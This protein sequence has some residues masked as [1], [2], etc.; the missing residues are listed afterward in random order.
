VPVKINKDK[1]LTR[2]TSQ[3]SR[4]FLY[5]SLGA[6]VARMFRL[7]RARFYENGI[8]SCNL[9]WDGQTLQAKATRSTHSHVLHLLSQLTTCLLDEEFVFENPYYAKTKTEVCLHLRELHHEACI[10]STRSCAESIY[11]A[12]KTHC[13]TCSQ[14]IDRRFATLASKCGMHDPNEHYKLNV[15]TDDLSTTHDR[16]MALGFMAFA[17]KCS[18][19]TRD[20]F[21]QACSSE[22]HQIARHMGAESVEMAL[23]SLFHLHRRHSESVMEVMADQL[24]EHSLPLVKATLPATCLIR[25]V[26]AGAHLGPN[27]KTEQAKDGKKKHGKGNL[28]A[29]VK[30]LLELHPEWNAVKIAKKIE[31]TTP[32]AVRKTKAWE[33][34]P[35]SEP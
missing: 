33:E 4:S 19:L 16:T 26:G 10:R 18:R 35:K 12:S 6:V 2:E 23:N 1:R 8:V 28:N 17:H 31:D 25:M 34:R 3:R 21:V 14:C 15:F 30:R 5:A 29:E 20:G 13:G 27:K 9:M 11:K 32:G 7:K 22:I 24:A